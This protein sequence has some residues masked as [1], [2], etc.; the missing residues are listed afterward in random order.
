M[1][2]IGPGNVQ[3][4]VISHATERN[5]GKT[6]HFIRDYQELLSPMHHLN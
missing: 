2:P 6:F 5:N 3:H 1:I 4:I